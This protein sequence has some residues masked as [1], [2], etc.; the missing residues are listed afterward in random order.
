MDLQNG[1]EVLF[2]DCFGVNSNSLAENL[3]IPFS[4]CTLEFFIGAEAIRKKSHESQGQSSG[5]KNLDDEAVQD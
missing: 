5:E 1:N 3:N 4:K 2:D